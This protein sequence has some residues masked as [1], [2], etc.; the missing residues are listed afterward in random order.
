MFENGCS[1]S[2]ALQSELIRKIYKAYQ[3]PI[4]RCFTQTAREPVAAAFRRCWLGQ[5]DLWHL[6]YGTLLAARGT[7]DATSAMAF[8]TASR[9]PGSYRV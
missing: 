3:L 4:K 8:I 5:R 9:T 7:L 6:L 1:T 2:G